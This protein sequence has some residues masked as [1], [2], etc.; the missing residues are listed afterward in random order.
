LKL[1]PDPY[2]NKKS[3]TRSGSALKSKFIAMEGL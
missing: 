1:N 3:K 2:K